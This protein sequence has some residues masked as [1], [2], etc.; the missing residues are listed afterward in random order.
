MQQVFCDHCGTLWER[1]SLTIGQ[2]N[3]LLDEL[4]EASGIESNARVL[5]K[6]L[7]CVA[8]ANPSTT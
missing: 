1:A 7:Q 4:A 5:G 2:L 6:L 3:D 8:L